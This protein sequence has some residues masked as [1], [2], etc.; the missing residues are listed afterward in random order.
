[1]TCAD[2]VLSTAPRARSAIFSRGA[3]LAPV[4]HCP[5][6]FV[7]QNTMKCEFA[8]ATISAETSEIVAGTSRVVEKMITNGL[9]SI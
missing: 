4:S 6:T 3:S 5:T 2:R 7:P 1:M 8:S 9:V